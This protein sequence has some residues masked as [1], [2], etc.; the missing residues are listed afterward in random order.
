MKIAIVDDHALFR[1]SLKLL[2]E[3]FGEMEV[4]LE[5]EDGIQLLNKLKFT[6]VDTVLLDLQMPRMDG[7]TTGEK[8]RELYPN[9]K[10]LVLTLLNDKESVHR[11]L[12][13][14]ADGYMTKKIEPTILKKALER[15]DIDGFYFDKEITNILEVSLDHRE[16]IEDFNLKELE[17]IQLSAQD[18]CSKKIGKELGLSHRTVEGV[19]RRL[20]MKTSSN[21]FLG[22]ILYA[23]KNGLVKI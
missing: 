22:V 14:G 1:K 3:S 18:F 19:K 4:N 10:I 23:L 7:F 8:L 2:I 15:I 17:I 13:W 20:I 6:T 16:R 11:T 21:S 9:I 12:K 5:A